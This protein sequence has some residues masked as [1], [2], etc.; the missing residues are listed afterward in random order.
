MFVESLRRDGYPVEN[1][2]PQAAIY[3]SV[4]MR[5]NGRRAGTR[6]LTTNED[7]R[8]WLLEAAHC[9]L[10]PFQAFGYRGET[11]WFRLS[12]GALPM[13]DLDLLFP[14]LRRALDTLE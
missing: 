4:Q 2:A 7:I 8:A 9:A 3:L 14:A 11:G 12:V 13:S 1:I 6:K 10:V 5:L